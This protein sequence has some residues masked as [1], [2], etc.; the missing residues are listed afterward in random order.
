MTPS[1]MTELD[2]NVFFLTGDTLKAVQ[3]LAEYR[4]MRKDMEYMGSERD[5]SGVFHFFSSYGVDPDGKRT[6]VTIQ[7]P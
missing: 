4:A 3:Q 1:Q 5:G 2:S 7:Q 6:R